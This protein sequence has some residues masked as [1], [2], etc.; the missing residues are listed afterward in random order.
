M[1]HEDQTLTSC[2]LVEPRVEG[3]GNI[4]EAGLHFIAKHKVSIELGSATVCARE[5]YQ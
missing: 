2:V 1:K 5:M 4:S 3:G